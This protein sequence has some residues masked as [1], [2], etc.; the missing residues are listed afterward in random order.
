MHFFNNFSRI[1]I[2][3]IYSSFIKFQD[4]PK[5]NNDLSVP[6]TLSPEIHDEDF[7]NT[8]DFDSPNQALG[9][10]E[11]HPG[12]PQSFSNPYPDQN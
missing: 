1:L 4:F 8:V 11:E 2:I 3:E 9:P 7:D 12:T 6:S 5:S 10:N